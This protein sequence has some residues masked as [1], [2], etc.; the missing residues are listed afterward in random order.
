MSKYINT[1]NLEKEGKTVG[2]KPGFSRETLIKDS[3]DKLRENI[4]NDFIKMKDA[5]VLPDAEKKKPANDIIKKNRA[6]AALKAATVV[7]KPGTA[8]V[9]K[10]EDGSLTIDKVGPNYTIKATKVNMFSKDMEST[11]A[12]GAVS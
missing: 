8:T 1:K 3:R 4:K 7:K 11:T 12:F 10:T 5:P 6:A 9:R 2:G